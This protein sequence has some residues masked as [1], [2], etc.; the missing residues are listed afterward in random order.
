MTTERQPTNYCAFHP[1]QRNIPPEHPAPF[2]IPHLPGFRPGFSIPDVTVLFR[3][4][5]DYPDHPV[6]HYLSEPL[7]FPASE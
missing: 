5:V 6:R 4:Y 2:Y 7:F 3:D 1:A